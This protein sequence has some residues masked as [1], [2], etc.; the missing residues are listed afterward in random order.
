M[1]KLKLLIFILIISVPIMCIGGPIYENARKQ[2]IDLYNKGRY[3]EAANQFIALQN[4][5]PVFND[6]TQWLSKCNRQ[7]ALQN[8]KKLISKK[9]L[10]VKHN[11]LKKTINRSSFQKDDFVVYDSIGSYNNEG[12]ALAMIDDKF[13]YVNKGKKVIVP[14]IYDNIDIFGKTS[15]ISV[16]DFYQ[17]ILRHKGDW[18]GIAMSVQRDGKWGFADKN[19]IEIIP[20]KYDIVEN[21]L[22]KKDSIVPVAINDKFGYINIKGQEV[23][24]LIYEF[25][26]RFSSDGIAPVVKNGKLGFIN[27][28]GDTIIDFIYD[29]KY[30]IENGKIQLL[31]CFWFDNITAVCK[32]GKW[33]LI[34]SIGEEVCQFIF[35]DYVTWS[36]QYLGNL[37][38]ITYTFLK[39]QKKCFWF[40]GEIY[41]DFDDLKEAELKI[42]AESKDPDSIYEL[43]AFY[44]D[45]GEYNPS[46]VWASKGD[47][48]N[49]AGCSRLLGAYWLFYT[50]TPSMA[51]Y[52]LRKAADQ[53]D[54]IAQYL[55]GL[56]YEKD[57]VTNNGKKRKKNDMLHNIINRSEAIE[58]YNKSANN[59][60][61]HAI[62]RL[63]SMGEYTEH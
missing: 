8:N 37:N 46:S 6:L 58:W 50:D 61:Q 49:H 14:V 56:M 19:G 62:E 63:K 23:I 21:F 60:N 29:P 33:G 41:Y 38:M 45:K 22:S 4:I 55:L 57:L 36:R 25:A 26:G 42:K 35:D 2:A 59:G 12:I 44:W 16:G 30:K 5:A 54:D 31:D 9:K 32:E 27:Y 1:V 51:D 3:L 53:N 24:P 47:E 52:Y 10:A 43:A 20:C 13:G 7:I 18:I 17:S 15:T 48:L 40:N 11:K 39:N 34:N 28:D